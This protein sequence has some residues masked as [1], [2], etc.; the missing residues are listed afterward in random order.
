MLLSLPAFCDDQ[1][2]AQKELNKITAMAADFT[3]RRTINLT[4]SETF[5][6]P[7]PKLVEG[8]GMTGLNYGS[9]FVAEQL[10]KDGTSIQDIATKLKTGENIFAIANEHH[11]DWKQVAGAAKK[12]NAAVDTNLYK[13]FL[14][15]KVGLAEDT[16]ASYDVHH[17]GVK[18]DAEISKNDL[19]DAQDR[20]VKWRDQAVRA[21]GSD[22]DKT[23]SAGDERVAY[24]DHVNSGPVGSGTAGPGGSV[25]GGQG[26]SAPVGM[27][28][29]H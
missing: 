23:L 20:F 17:D 24:Q 26:N 8:R 3:G 11:T 13:Y 6:V 27:G 18:D 29:P 15:E 12:F 21:Q 22:R 19:S 9:L 14:H 1:Q 28:G 2:K 10:V 4:M 5:S 16:A 25:S 7:R